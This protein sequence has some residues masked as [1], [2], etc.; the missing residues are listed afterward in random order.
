M[1][2]CTYT[3][4]VQKMT[5]KFE[6]LSFSMMQIIHNNKARH[7][8]EHIFT[9]HTCWIF[10]TSACSCFNFCFAE[11]S[12]LKWCKIIII[13]IINIPVVIALVATS[14]PGVGDPFYLT[15]AWN[16][17]SSCHAKAFAF[18]LPALSAS[19][20]VCDSAPDS[21]SVLRVCKASLF[22][23]TGDGCK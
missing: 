16:S 3:Q 5:W 11:F 15:L 13:M 8:N 1:K 22:T 21:S 7:G 18:E 23:L 17:G 14:S 20:S 4:S 19:V 10:F 9:N 12:F 2:Y 6:T